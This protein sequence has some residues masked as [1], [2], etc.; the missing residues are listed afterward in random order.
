M[1]LKRG[2][3]N[4]NKSSLQS[5][6]TGLQATCDNKSILKT[7]SRDI[8]RV[9]GTKLPFV[10]KELQITLANTAK[11]Q[12]TQHFCLSQIAFFL[13]LRQDFKNMLWDVVR[14][15][16]LTQKPWKTLFPSTKEAHFTRTRWHISC[17][18]SP[19]IAATISKKNIATPWQNTF[20]RFHPRW[21]G[22]QGGNPLAM[23]PQVLESWFTWGTR[24][25][26][27]CTYT[28]YTCM[29]LCIMCIN[30]YMRYRSLYICV[31]SR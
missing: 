25:L 23:V 4:S 3:N 22:G 16:D 1:N 6:L 30:K 31:C 19:K 11:L 5:V 24:S 20:D 18:T 7:E 17:Y 27:L 13:D 2:C 29:S 14:V 8:W 26:W 9:W 12:K 28:C 15:F 10:T 21:S